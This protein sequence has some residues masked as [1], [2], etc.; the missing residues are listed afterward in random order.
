M[1][2]WTVNHTGTGT[3]SFINTFTHYFNVKSLVKKI[4]FG[5]FNTIV[6]IF[7]VVLKPAILIVS[8][9][10]IGSG[11]LPTT[12]FEKIFVVRSF[13]QGFI[14]KKGWKG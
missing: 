2:H 1:L 7:Y 10:L 12:F 13:V 6:L 14:F 11:P 4:E 5:H 9:N 8:E 3:Q